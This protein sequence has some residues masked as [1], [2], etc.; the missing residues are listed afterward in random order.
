MGTG[1][2][3]DHYSYLERLKKIGN[4]PMHGAGPYLGLRFQM[5][6]HEAQVVLQGWFRSKEIR[7]KTDDFQNSNL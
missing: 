4:V 2:Q 5:T 3:Q 1:N 6:L 7:E